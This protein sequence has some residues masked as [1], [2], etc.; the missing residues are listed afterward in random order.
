MPAAVHIRGDYALF[1][2]LQGRVTVLD[3]DGNIVAQV[4]DNPVAGQRAN[5]VAAAALLGDFA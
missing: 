2:E 1:P 4:G 3:K 5:Y